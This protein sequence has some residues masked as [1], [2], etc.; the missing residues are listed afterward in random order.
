MDFLVGVVVLKVLID[1]FP[2]FGMICVSGCSQMKLL[3]QDPNPLNILD[4]RR[5]DYIPKHFEEI[6]IHIDTF[7]DH[8]V[9]ESID[10]WIYNNLNGRYSVVQDLDLLDNQSKTIYKIGFEDSSEVSYFS[11]AC[12]VL[13]EPTVK[14]V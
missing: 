3:I 8:G 9:V 5:L 2:N 7:L 14:I 12:P 11:L 1:I 13:A 10:S 6:K 4:I